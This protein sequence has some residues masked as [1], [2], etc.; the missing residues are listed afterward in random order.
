MLRSLFGRF[1]GPKLAPPPVLISNNEACRHLR[2][3]QSLAE[4]VFTVID[5]EL[6]GLSPR[7]D[8]IV[9]LGA[10]RVQGLS[11]V[12]EK[13]FSALVR[14]KKGVPKKSTLIHRI[15]PAAVAEAP[16]LEEV[17]PSFLQFLHGTFVVGHHIGLD[18]QFLRH[19]CRTAYGVE[20]QNPC[21]D[22]LRL[23]MIWREERLTSPYDRYD[24]RISYHL[25]DLAEELGL[26]TFPAHDALADA[27]QTA[28]LFVYLANKLAT[29][30]TPLAEL[31]ALGRSWRWYL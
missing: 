28:Y 1:L 13:T 23:A 15:T 29:P 18:M 21:L 6:T 27:L 11:I 4:T 31:F 14:P 30:H 16:A 3:D 12:A 10:V 8:E 26:P 7:Q 17:L 5:T 9:A 22:T 2:Q 25:A 19:A 20:P 24:L